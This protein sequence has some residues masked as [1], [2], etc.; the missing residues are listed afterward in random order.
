MEPRTPRLDPHSRPRH[1]LLPEA[2]R[3][4]PKTR[5]KLAY[6]VGRPRSSRP[7]RGSASTKKPQSRAPGSTEPHCRRMRPDCAGPGLYL[8]V[9]SR[10][11]HRKE[12]TGEGGAT[13]HA[14]YPGSVRLGSRGEASRKTPPLA[15]PR[16]LSLA[17]EKIVYLRE[18]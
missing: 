7:A 18:C 12:R 17:F 2:R 8:R 5:R 16:R 14:S 3:Q 11:R 6:G 4:P 9:F 1:R 10:L 15:F 13:G